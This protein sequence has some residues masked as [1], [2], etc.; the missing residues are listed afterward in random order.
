MAA[1]RKLGYEP[2]P[3][4]EVD[5]RD[6]LYSTL[7]KV[8]RYAD[9]VRLDIRG[10]IKDQGSFGT[11]VAFATAYTSDRLDKRIN[12]PL[13]HYI[14]TKEDDAFPGEEGTRV[15]DSMKAYKKWGSVPE[16]LLPY[17]LYKEKLV[18][19]PVSESLKELGKQTKI[20]AYAKITTKEELTDHLLHD[21]GEPAIG[22]FIV[23]LTSLFNPEHD[24]EGNAILDMPEGPIK[25]HAMAIF[26][27]H[28]KMQWKY[29][30]GVVRTGFASVPNSWGLQAAVREFGTGEEILWSKT[31]YCYIPFDYLFGTMWAPDGSRTPYVNEIFVP[32]RNIPFDIVKI[33][34][35]NQNITPYI[36]NSRAMA[37]LRFVGETLGTKVIYHEQDRGIDII[38]PDGKRVSLNIESKD[39]YIHYPEG[40]AK[41][42]SLDVYPEVRGDRTFVPVR[43]IAESF[44]ADVE[45]FGHEQRIEIKHKD[46]IIEMWIGRN[47]ARKIVRKR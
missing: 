24:K 23:G 32:L 38:S 6:L 25:G 4:E 20:D 2:L 43:A 18:F 42:V 35:G 26:G 39:M 19:P 10:D 8:N 16:E 45:Y 41:K 40:N 5:N 15:T 11:C 46:T 9:D 22:G 29:K 47:E 21:G 34:P 30:N 28:H 7:F 27:A 17:S 13:Y 12:S 37:P 31:G 3:V 44:D 14:M 36:K 33:D 1:E